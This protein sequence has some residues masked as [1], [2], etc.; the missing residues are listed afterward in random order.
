MYPHAQNT[1][2]AEETN[3]EKAQEIPNT[4]DALMTDVDYERDDP[5]PNQD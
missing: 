2:E 5:C 3:D 4:N 1:A